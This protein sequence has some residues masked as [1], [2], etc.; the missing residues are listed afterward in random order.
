MSCEK[1]FKEILLKLNEYTQLLDLNPTGNIGEIATQIILLKAIDKLN[2]TQT[3][4]KAYTVSEFLISFLGNDEFNLI[5]QNI[6]DDIKNGLVCFSHFIRKAD[7]L[8]FN[9]VLPGFIGRAAAGQFKKGHPVFD[10]FIPI[11]LENN[12]ITYILIQVKNKKD[13]GPSEAMQILNEMSKPSGLSIKK[14]FPFFFKDNKILAHLSILISL[15][16]KIQHKL[17]KSNWENKI[18]YNLDN[19]TKSKLF[20]EEPFDNFLIK[21]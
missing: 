13:L 7:D 3:F 11:V 9:D 6:D 10:L 14:M 20:N 18:F 2:T 5:K 12:N 4:S 21:M 16:D 19:L 1:K 15:G 8:T 17:P